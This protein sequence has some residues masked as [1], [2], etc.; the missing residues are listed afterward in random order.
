MS[1][2]LAM[3]AVSLLALRAAQPSAVR[4]APRM[5][6]GGNSEQMLA[7]VQQELK[8]IGDEIKPV[9]EQALAQSKSAG[10]VSAETKATAD[11]LLSQQTAFGKKQDELVNQLEGISS[12]Q[13]ELE[14]AFADGG[15]GNGSGQV[16]TMGQAFIAEDEKI[17]SFVGNGC[18]GTLAINVGNAITTADGSGGGLIY[19][20]EER[21]PVNMPRRRLRIRQLITQG[22]T[23]SDLVKYRRQTTRTD[24]TAMVAEEGT[25]P[26]SA[27][28]WTKAETSV[29]KIGAFTNISEESMDDADFLQSE[30]DTELRH[31]LD[32]EEE[33]Q[34]LAG[35]GTGENLHGLIPNATVFAAAAGL[36]NATHI[37]RLRL[38]IL[39]VAL[40]DYIATGMVLH[41]TDWAAIELLKVGVADDRYIFG[42][43][44]TGNTPMLWGKDVVDSNSMSVGEWLV[45]DFALAAT[46]YDRSD[47]EVLISSEHDTNFIEDML[48][49]KARKR[50]ALA[51]KRPAALVTGN[52]TFA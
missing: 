14:Q 44:A 17:K 34:I 27:F 37:D 23:S 33:A 46:I 3:P 6:S 42:N 50:V 32:L 24:A 45:G 48:T 7:Q 26:E 12:K 47:A 8:R 39:Q 35:D 18:S 21:T 1:R 22:R 28:G 5:D 40:A 30:I 10:E 43:P 13:T 19:H 25:Y 11:K 16:M 36:P 4:G 15:R 49:M 2:K 38:A 41:P 20:E 9:A 52:F 51:N 31:G 29:K